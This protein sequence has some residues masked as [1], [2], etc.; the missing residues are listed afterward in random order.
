MN[1]RLEELLERFA[2]W[3]P[4]AQEEA[5]ASLE[6]IEVTVNLNAGLSPAQQEA[7]LVALREMIHRSIERGGSYT[8]DDIDVMIDERF[9]DS[10]A[11]GR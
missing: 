4:D 2:S 8:P 1:K 9:G 10:R 3:P 6:S 11:Q 5:I 7:K